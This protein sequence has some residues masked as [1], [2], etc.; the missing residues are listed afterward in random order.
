M[1]QSDRQPNWLRIDANL[2][3]IFPDAGAHVARC[4][5]LQDILDRIPGHELLTEILYLSPSVELTQIS[6]PAITGWQ[7]KSCQIAM[8][9]G[10]AYSVRLDPMIAR[11]VTACNGRQQLGHL[12][13]AVAIAAGEDLNVVVT[14]YL[15]VLR[16]LV[17]LGFLWPARHGFERSSAAAGSKPAQEML[18]EGRL[19]SAVPAE[20][21][22]QGCDERKARSA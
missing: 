15:G 20:T 2:P 21:N 5:W 1:R 3:R 9:R 6:K 7:V 19:A 13:Q 8:T 10:I 22:E 17:T 12:L 4:F 16:R 11:V 18:E 14:R